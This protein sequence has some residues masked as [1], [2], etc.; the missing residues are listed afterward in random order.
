[1]FPRLSQALQTNVVT[2]SQ[3]VP[4]QLPSAAQIH[5]ALIMLRVRVI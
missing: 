2:V 4:R 3:I 1:M 5:I